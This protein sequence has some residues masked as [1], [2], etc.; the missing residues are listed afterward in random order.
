MASVFRELHR[1]EKCVGYKSSND[2]RI[3]VP[4]IWQKSMQFCQYLGSICPRKARGMMCVTHEMSYARKV[5]NRGILM[6]AHRVLRGCEK[7]ELFGNN[8][9]MPGGCTT[10]L[11]GSR[12]LL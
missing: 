3:T 9:T 8:A 12:R 6:D 11:E 1:I 4:D 7:A 10:C 5:V 2:G